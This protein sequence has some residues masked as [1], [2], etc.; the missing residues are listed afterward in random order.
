VHLRLAHQALAAL[1]A[2]LA[3]PAP[4]AAQALVLTPPRLVVRGA[5]APITLAALDV[6]VVIQG[7]TAETTE[8]LVFRNPNGRA[9]EGALEFPL[10]DAAAVAGFALDVDGQLVEGAVLPRQQARVV[11]EAELRRGVD[12]GLVEHVRGNVYRARIYPI[13]A[14]G[15]RTVRLRW[16]SPLTTGDGEAAYHLPL[17]YQLSVPE[18]A[19]RVEVVGAPVKPE[20]LGGFGNLSLQRQDDRWVAEERL[21]DVAAR[22]DLLVRLPRL[23]PRWL[24]V[25][26][27]D[28]G[29]SFFA[30]AERIP[31]LEAK[32]AIP[33]PRRLAL[34]WDAS[35]SREAAA[36][37]RELAFLRQLLAAWPN[38]GVDLVVFRDRPERPR[39]FAAG[40]LARLEAALRALPRDGGTALD[41]LDLRRSALPAADDDLWVVVS[42]GLATLGEALPPAGDVP[43]WTVTG[44]TEADR[45]LL[46]HLSTSTGGEAVDLVALAPQAVAARFTAPR[47]RLVQVTAAPG[48]VA[49][50]QLRA[51]PDLAWAQVSGR[52]LVPEAELSLVFAA[53]AKIVERRSVT[54]RRDAA[55]P[56]SESPGPVALTW[57]Q[58]RAE[59]L[60]LFPERNEEALLAL[61]RRFGLVTPAT[62][63]LVLETLAQHL[64]HGVE[65]AASRPALRAQYLARAAERA[66]RQRADDRAALE[67]VVA[68]WQDRVA[69]WERRFDVPPGW[70]WAEQRQ[71]SA[72]AQREG[73]AAREEEM[74]MASPALAGAPAP[75]AAPSR[76]MAKASDD[77][78]AGEASA[79]AAIAIRPWDPGVPYLAALKAAAPG[80]AYAAYLVERARHAGPAF[81]LDCAGFFLRAGQ[82][83]LGI[84]V[85]TNLAE[86]RLDDPALL[87]VLAWRLSEAGELDLAAQ[88]LDK[89]LRLRPEE[90]QSRRDLALVL[91]ER[92]EAK[93]HPADAARAVQLLW[94]VGRRSWERAPDLELVSLMELNRILARAERRGW[95]DVGKAAPVDPRVKKLL[96]LDLRV[97]LAWDTDMTDVDL[98]LLE[99]TEEH[100]FYGHRETRMGGLVSHDVTQGYG[101]EEYLVR[102]ALPGAYAVKVHYYGS[103]AQTLVGPATLIA[104]V[105]TNWG[106]A[107]ER[108]EV[109]TLRLDGP[110]DLES[111]GVVWIGGHAGA[112]P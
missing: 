51:T 80:A 108:R 59:A 55:G 29:G 101:P 92:A 49:D 72:R 83:E 41:A 99:P 103:G 95:A 97:S 88:L 32:A 89:V 13:P 109:L 23:P 15:T 44:A 82:R 39:A 66:V 57:A 34:A 20:V 52:L 75:S 40:D 64:E 53:G 111:V 76:V 74:D 98:H 42:D 10:P 104:T 9:L 85:L 16:I 46:R 61:G 78:S 107:D 22:R 43:V 28:D 3:A 37:D 33:A 60:G 94:E 112:T 102:R 4:A 100:A 105:Y 63:I 7:F 106:R 47:V 58:A 67:A 38:T 31:A 65:P 11:L 77:R 87:R 79:D 1:V 45:A 81:Y 96:T 30:L 90:P 19:M 26:R 25:E 86:L 70:R 36:V 69:W 24:S 48:A 68:A 12:P 73:E 14:L 50:L 54:V 17:P 6:R 27:A 21:R 93:G 84:R 18:V 8:T 62:S 56:A 110:R 71:K 91:A 2:L 35:A 5:E